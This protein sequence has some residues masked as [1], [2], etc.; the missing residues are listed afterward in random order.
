M[1]S[2]G[3]IAGREFVAASK[4]YQRC[5]VE[6]DLAQHLRVRW[7]QAGQNVFDAAADEAA[8]RDVGR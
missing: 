7:P 6:I 8:R 1:S 4:I 3:G 5:F 2:N